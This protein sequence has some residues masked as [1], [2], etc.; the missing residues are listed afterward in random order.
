MRVKP[1]VEED[2]VQA[3]HFSFEVAQEVDFHPVLRFVFLERVGG[4]DADGENEHPTLHEFVVVVAP[5]AQLSRARAGERDGKEG[6]E[7]GFASERLKGHLLAGR[8]R[9]R[10]VRRRPTHRGDCVRFDCSHDN[11]SSNE[12]SDEIYS[13]MV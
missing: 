11:I 4:I 13:A 3:R 6:D 10:E 8:R 12:R 9:Q 2:A 7:D 5:L 1:V